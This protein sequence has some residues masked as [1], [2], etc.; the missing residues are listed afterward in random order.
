[1]L[2]CHRKALIV[3]WGVIDRVQKGLT[4]RNL[5][6]LGQL[7]DQTAAGDIGDLKAPQDAAPGATVKQRKRLG[8]EVDDLALVGVALAGFK[9][10]D[11]TGTAFLGRLK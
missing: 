8:I 6:R 9:D 4:T 7:D 3:V 11:D 2:W 5:K 10:N 1:V